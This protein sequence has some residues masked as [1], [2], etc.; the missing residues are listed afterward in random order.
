MADDWSARLAA[1]QKEMRVQVDHTP[2]VDAVQFVTGCDLTVKGDLMVGCFVVVDVLN[3]CKSIYEKCSIVEVDVPYIPGL[4]CFREGPVVVGC[5]REFRT[6]FPDLKINVLLVD[7]CGE[8]HPRGFR[9]A[10]YVGLECGIPTI[11]VSKSFLNTRSGH[12]GTRVQIDA[13]AEC[14]NF[15]DAM[16]LHHGIDGGIPIDCAVMRTTTSVPFKPIVVSVGHLICIDSA[17]QIVRQLCR[18]REP[19]PLRLADR[20]SCEF[21]RRMKANRKA[22]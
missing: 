16:V 22:A 18:F 19:E 14:P 5:L 3:E 2:R 6:E 1:L 10:C 4:L 12:T 17:V 13:Q 21:V 11:G 20:I 7:G 8:W 15:G 9:L